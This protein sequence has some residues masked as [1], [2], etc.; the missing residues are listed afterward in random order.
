MRGLFSRKN[1]PSA[2]GKTL[3]PKD[4]FR[5]GCASI[6]KNTQNRAVFRRKD[7]SAATENS[8]KKQKR[9][10]RHHTPSFPL[11]DAIF[12]NITYVPKVI[13]L[14]FRTVS[15]WHPVLPDPH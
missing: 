6:R 5:S 9:D 3:F 1:R 13:C 15:R 7:F 10:L 4:L 14:K 12:P 11:L 8:G 2:G